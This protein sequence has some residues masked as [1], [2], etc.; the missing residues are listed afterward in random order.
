MKR[1]VLINPNTSDATTADMVDI[2]RASAAGGLRI[3]GLTARFGAR[4]ITCEAELDEAARAVLALVPDVGQAADA[5]IVAAF[6]DPAADALAKTLDRPVIG[7]AEASMRAAALG[8]RRFAVVTTTP[9]LIRRISARAEELGLGGSCV[10]VLATDGDPALLM[11]SAADLEHRLYELAVH[12]V[13]ALGA[14]AIVVGGGP[15]G[16]V[17]RALGG[18]LDVPVIEPIPEAVRHIARV[19]GAASAR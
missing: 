11:Q 9:A 2:A 12:A 8:G 13:S 18:R 3:D 17:A 15:L 16:R 6:G 4:L 14:Q 10:G 5:V 1:I 19:L 7:I